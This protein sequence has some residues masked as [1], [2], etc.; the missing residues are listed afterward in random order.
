MGP[1]RTNKMT[2]QGEAST[3]KLETTVKAKPRRNH[4]HKESAA[5]PG[6]QKIKASLRQA[7]RLL[8]KDKVAA[9]VRVETER[10]IKA[11]EADLE[12]AKISKTERTNAVRYH[13]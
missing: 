5:L 10:R 13:K 4:P 11:L 2:R 3:S 1:E 7:R 8:A 9:D 12:Q 6:V